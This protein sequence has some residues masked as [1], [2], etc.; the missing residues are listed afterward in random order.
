MTEAGGLTN[1]N[2]RTCPARYFT[3]RKT[4]KIQ[5]PCHNG[6]FDART[7]DRLQGPP[8]RPLPQ[9]DLIVKGEEIYVTRPRAHRMST[10][11]AKPNR[12]A[13]PTK[14]NTLLLGVMCV[15]ILILSHAGLAADGGLE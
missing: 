3:S 9:L 7:G 6:W 1:R 8:P 2:A 12:Q 14:T 13:H 5:C 11:S 15:L 4:D 10:I